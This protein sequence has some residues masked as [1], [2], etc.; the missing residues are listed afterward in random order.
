MAD[1]QVILQAD[2]IGYAG[3]SAAENVTA[4]S[5]A[6][7][8]T[9]IKIINY[10]TN[11]P[12]LNITPDF[13]NGQMTVLSDGNYSIDGSFSFSADTGNL[14]TF[15]SLFIGGVEQNNIHFTR[16]IGVGGDV[17]N[18]S[19]TGIVALSN[20]DIIDVRARHDNGSAVDFT[21]PYMNLNILKV[22]N[23]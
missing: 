9:Y 17:G 4:Q 14:E 19:L 22:D 15:F 5:I 6:N 10:D 2:F 7:G 11:E 1:L 20:G 21:F 13:T 16:K 3:I 12:S 18:A 8:A 23:I